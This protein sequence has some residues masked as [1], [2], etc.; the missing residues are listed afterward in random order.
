MTSWKNLSEHPEEA[1][2]Q[3]IDLSH[4]KKIKAHFSKSDFTEVK[5]C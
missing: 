2:S 1:I 5:D 4:T 3:S